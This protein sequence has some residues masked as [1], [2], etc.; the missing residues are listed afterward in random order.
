LLYGYGRVY[1]GVYA[2]TAM[3]MID[4]LKKAGY[5]DKEPSY[6]QMIEMTDIIYQYRL[7]YYDDRRIHRIEALTAV[8][9]YLQQQG[10]A[11]DFG[12]G[13]QLIIQDVWD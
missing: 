4:E 12:T 11:D 6:P 13:G 9:E 1:N 10:L 7:K 3:Y 5:I 2:A 8:G